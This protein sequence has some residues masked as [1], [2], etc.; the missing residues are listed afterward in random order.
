MRA[1]WLELLKAKWELTNIRMLASALVRGRTSLRA[2][3]A[4]GLVSMIMV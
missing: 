4:R 1:T 2:A 3:Q